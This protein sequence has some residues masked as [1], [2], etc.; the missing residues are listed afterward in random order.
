MRILGHFLL[1]G[2]LYGGREDAEVLLSMSDV[3][4]G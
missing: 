3:D 1:L 4:C 2:V